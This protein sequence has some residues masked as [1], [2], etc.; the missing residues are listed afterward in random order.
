MEE[1]GCFVF[2][3]CGKI[4]SRIEI[5]SCTPRIILRTLKLE[6]EPKALENPQG[7]L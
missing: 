1:P 7:F 2:G 6:R 3:K 4:F 5:F